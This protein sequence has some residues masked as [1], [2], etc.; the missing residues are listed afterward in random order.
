ME[1]P[2]VSL[3]E[4]LLILFTGVIAFAAVTSIFQDR[5]R[6]LLWHPELDL[7][8]EPRPPDC[9]KTGWYPNPDVA[10]GRTLPCY[11]YRAR[12]HNNGKETARHIEV[13]IQ[14][15]R[16]KTTTGAWEAFERFIPQ[17]LVWAIV[18]PGQTHLPMLLPRSHRHFDLAHV[19]R[20]SDRK[21]LPREH[22]ADAPEDRTVVSLN[23]DV[24]YLRKG[25][26]LPPGE[27][28]ITLTVG[29]INAASKNFV[30]ELNS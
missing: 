14:D 4:W 19:V 28:R 5:I 2:A 7:K 6:A 11:Y 25:H 16:R 9:H 15:I 23:V 22:D 27:Y 20:P 8:I 10:L 29:G 24:P 13:F 21:L 18:P 30:L 1:D 12:I 3:N 26:L 17:Y